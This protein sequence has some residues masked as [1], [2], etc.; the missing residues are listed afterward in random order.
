MNV[1]NGARMRRL[2][3]RVG[4]LLA[5]LLALTL[6]ATAAASTVW[7]PVYRVN[8]DSTT[9][10][11]VVPDVAL[12]PSGAAIGV[13]QDY[14]ASPP[15]NPFG[16]I[17]IFASRRDPT[18]GAWAANV[19]VND[20]AT[21]Q[22]FKPAVA[23]DATDNAY[24]VWVDRRNGSRS[25]IYF[26]KRSAS[27]GLWSSNVRVN[28]ST[29]FETQDKPTIAV[30]SSGDAIALWTRSAKN[31]LNVWSARLPVGGSTWGPEM[32]V[33]ANQSTAKQGPRVAFGPTGTAHAVWMD[34][35]VGN[36]DIWYATLPSGSSTWSN[37]TNISDDPGTAFQGPTDIA[38]DG[39]GDVMVA[40]TDRRATPYQLR[41]RRLPAGGSWGAS[42]IVAADGG[43]SP[44]LAVRADGMAFLA[45][46]DG[47]T[48][49]PYPKLWGATY[50]P[51]AGTWSAPERIDTN[52]S[53]HGAKS[54]ATALDASRIVVLWSNGLS[55]PSGENDDD[56]LARVG[57]P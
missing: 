8:D 44:S 20:V 1:V 43:N 11:Q 30:S 18:T 40:W 53:D 19:R 41:V 35:A 3:S 55:V 34:P 16:E 9:T 5:M 24:A 32:R 57:T 2:M 38:V 51:G 33:T 7:D 17:D 50:D 12:A 21:G 36:A 42:S 39:S 26:S 46:H 10:S 29:S 37:N 47:D 25:D 14:R 23:V 56:V 45:W 4:S 13:W 6:P 54:A 49:T 15:G 22:Q 31:K 28:S 48:S 27:T 52:G